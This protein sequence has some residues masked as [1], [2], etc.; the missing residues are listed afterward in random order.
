MKTC[1]T[2]KQEFPET[3]E[4]FF[5]NSNHKSL[6]SNCKKCHGQIK[7]KKDREKKCKELG[8][9]IKDYETYKR[10]E[11]LSRPIF[12]LKN[13]KLKGIPRSY[14]ARILKKEREEGYVF[15]TFEQYKLDVLKIRSET[16]RK[17]NYK[18]C[19]KLSYEIIKDKLPDY[20]IANRFRKKLSELPKEMIET[21]RLIIQLKRETNGK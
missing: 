19:V 11:L 7:V 2:C 13:E 20:Y 5:L 18:D 17:Y 6:R 3:T 4:Y 12:Q 14:R 1:S 9:N 10:N 8:I 15:T 21:K 16:Q